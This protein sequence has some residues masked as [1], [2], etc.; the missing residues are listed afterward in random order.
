[1]RRCEASDGG[2]RY[3]GV[4]EELMCGKCLGEVA[5]FLASGG[6]EDALGAGLERCFEL[7]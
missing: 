4:D 3:G 2:L 1:M 5:I 6:V 7:R